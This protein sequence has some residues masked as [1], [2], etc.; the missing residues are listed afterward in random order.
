[1]TKERHLSN[2]P[3]IEAVIDLRVKRNV[4]FEI[5]SLTSLK[6]SLEK[7][8]P[9]C[10]EARSFHFA[11]KN[12]LNLQFEHKK[13]LLHGYLLKTED[14][15]KAIQLKRDGLC[16]SHL[17]PYTKWEDL[18]LKAKELW[19]LYKNACDPEKITRV[20]L[21]YINHIN[22]PNEKIAFA[23]YL[24]SPPVMPKGSTQNINSFLSKIVFTYS[25][26]NIMA[27]F[28]QSYE[29]R[30]KQN[31]PTIIIDIDVYQNKEYEP[32][33]KNV[34]PLF[35]QFRKIK[36]DLFFGNITEKTVEMFE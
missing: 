18:F 21:R 5:S 26:Q 29:F 17:Q 20:A 11:V 34:W 24:E 6:D 33:D 31:L 27:N 30:G 1:M 32:D 36:N 9:K 8:F 13:E 22:V 28:I 14:E 16:Y 2:P 23:D 12:E 3:I 10:T 7:S 35:D 15:K 19:G 4:N 25:Q